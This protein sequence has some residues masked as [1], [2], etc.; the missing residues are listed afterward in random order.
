[1]MYRKSFIIKRENLF[2][3]VESDHISKIEI[4]N[5][6]N[7]SLRDRS[8]CKIYVYFKISC[9]ELLTILG[10]CKKEMINIQ[11]LSSDR[12]FLKGIQNLRGLGFLPEKHLLKLI[13]IE[14]RNGINFSISND[15]RMMSNKRIKE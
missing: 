14:Q 3:W 12:Q 2:K 5:T 9:E 8:L 4:T 7:K 1:M 6:Y 10:C 15:I 11:V 13:D